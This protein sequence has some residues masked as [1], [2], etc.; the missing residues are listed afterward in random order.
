MDPDVSVL[1]LLFELFVLLLFE[2]FVLL[3][4]ILLLLVSLVVVEVEPDVSF[5]ES[6]SVDPEV[7]VVD[8]EPSFDFDD[9][10][11][12]DDFDRVSVEL[13]DFGGFGSSFVIIGTY[14]YANNKSTQ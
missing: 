8:L 11:P 3:L 1:P 7:C 4:F 14:I 5:E 2:L 10:L 13:S 12:G 6:P 9:L